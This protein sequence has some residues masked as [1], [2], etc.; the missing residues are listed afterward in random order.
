MVVDSIFFFPGFHRSHLELLDEQLHFLPIG[1]KFGWIHLV[2]ADEA[3]RNMMD[4]PSVDAIGNRLNDLVRSIGGWRL[5]S[6]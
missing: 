3:N 2:V 4:C 1:L 5:S 6:I